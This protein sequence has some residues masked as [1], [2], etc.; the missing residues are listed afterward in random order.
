MKLLALMP[1]E[2]WLS[3]LSTPPNDKDADSSGCLGGHF[4]SL[5]ALRSEACR[6]WPP[7]APWPRGDTN[8]VQ[9]IKCSVPET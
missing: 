1:F 5:P 6:L 8:R 4:H 9:N 2:H 3:H 7:G